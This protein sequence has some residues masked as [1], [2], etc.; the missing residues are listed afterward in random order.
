MPTFYQIVMPSRCFCGAL[1]VS[2][3][4]RLPLCQSGRALPGCDDP[5]ESA[6]M[7][8]L[9]MNDRPQY[10]LIRQLDNGRH[11]VICAAVS[12]QDAQLPVIDLRDRQFKTLA[13]MRSADDQSPITRQSTQ[14]IGPSLATDIVLHDIDSPAITGI[15]GL[16]APNPAH[17]N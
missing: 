14:G 8:A 9:C 5:H 6:T 4:F 13:G 11:L 10:P 7:V 15:Q 2:G 3:G 1:T 16:A 12:A 17:D